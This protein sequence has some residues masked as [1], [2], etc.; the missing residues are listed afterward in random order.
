MPTEGVSKKGNIFVHYTISII[1]ILLS[2]KCNDF[3]HS[4][5]C[6]ISVFF[7]I[8]FEYGFLIYDTV[9]VALQ[10]VIAT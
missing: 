8:L 1:H 3:N 7:R 4:S 6:S 10:V 9:A 2:S 5:F